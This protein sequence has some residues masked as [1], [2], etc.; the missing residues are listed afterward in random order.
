VL[1]WQRTQEGWR[2]WVVY[3]VGA[4]DEQALAVQ[5]WVDPGQLTPVTPVT[6]G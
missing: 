5:A 1:S 3:L 2:A 6:G 4:P